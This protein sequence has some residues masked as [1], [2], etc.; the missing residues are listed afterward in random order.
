MTCPANSQVVPLRP[1]IVR[2]DS[3]ST[4]KRPLVGIDTATWR[5][6]RTSAAIDQQQLAER[7]AQLRQWR[8][9]HVHDSLATVQVARELHATRTDNAKLSTAFTQQA[10]RANKAL[11]LPLRPPLLL[12]GRLYTGVA[13][14]G[15]LAVVVRVGIKLIFNR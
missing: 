1:H 15:V 12:D 11:A 8:E 10:D 3:G 2:L 6:I 9:L 13:T 7:A 14:G 4:A 5:S